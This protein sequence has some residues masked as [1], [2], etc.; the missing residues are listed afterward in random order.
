MLA[1]AACCLGLG[2]MLRAEFERRTLD[3]D[4]AAFPTQQFWIKGNE[5]WWDLNYLHTALT[6]CTEEGRK[7]AK[8]LK[9][10][11]MQVR[12]VSIVRDG[13][14]FLHL[15]GKGDV[16][17]HILPANA[18]ST[19]S[20]LTFYWVSVDVSMRPQE[21]LMV[22]NVLRNVAQRACSAIHVPEDGH[23]YA[24]TVYI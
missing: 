2:T 23:V 13:P 21:K 6:L 9:W 22:S 11:E 17:I 7:R 8:W 20:T 5:I 3:D 15:N 4:A 19:L 24:N 16:P 18:S 14:P 12:S 1:L 10:F